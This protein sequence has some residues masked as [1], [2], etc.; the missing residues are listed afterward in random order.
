MAKIRLPEWRRRPSF[1][2]FSLIC[3]VIAIT[4]DKHYLSVVRTL[5]NKRSM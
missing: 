2:P 4:S 1:L 3:G 5:T